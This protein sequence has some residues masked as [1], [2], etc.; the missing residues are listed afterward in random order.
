MIIEDKITVGAKC[1]LMLPSFHADEGEYSVE[2]MNLF[3]ERIASEIT[4]YAESELSIRRYKADY[5]ISKSDENNITVNIHLTARRKERGCP[6]E[7][8]S[9]CL[10]QVWES[11]VLKAYSSTQ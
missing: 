8:R 4:S 9:K 1:S 2:K 10:T 11:G 7:A 5:L 3:Y 6:A